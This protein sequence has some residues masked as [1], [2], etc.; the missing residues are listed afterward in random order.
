MCVQQ[1]EVEQRYK[2]NNTQT[3]LKTNDIMWKGKL[4]GLWVSAA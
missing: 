3:N 1:K 2:V 4:G